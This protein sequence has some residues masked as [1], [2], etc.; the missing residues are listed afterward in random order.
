MAQFV[1][2][3]APID[4]SDQSVSAQ[5]RTAGPTDGTKTGVAGVIAGINLSSIFGKD[6]FKNKVPVT[7]CLK[8]APS[9]SGLLPAEW[10][11]K[12]SARFI[13]CMRTLLEKTTSEVMGAVHSYMTPALYVMILLATVIIGIK[14]VGG[15]F[16]NVKVEAVMFVGKVMGAL[17]VFEN[18]DNIAILFYDITDTLMV[19][20]AGGA[21][22]TFSAGSVFICDANINTSAY[23]DL[24]WIGVFDWMD[25]LFG[26]LYGFGP[27]TILSAGLFGIVGAGFFTSTIGIHFAMMAIGF[28]IALAMFLVRTATMVVMAYGSISL[29]MLMLPVFILT[30]FFKA[31]ESY[32]FQRWLSMVIRN[33]MQPAVM[34]AFLYFALGVL[35]VLLYKGSEGHY[36]K[37]G[38]IFTAAAN[39]PRKSK[40]LLD[41]EL[42]SDIRRYT[43]GTQPAGY[44]KV[45]EPVHEILGTT[46]NMLSA[47][48]SKLVK[49]DEKLFE[50]EITADSTVFT[51]IEQRCGKA[52]YWDYATTLY[53]GWKYRNMLDEVEASGILDKIVADKDKYTEAINKAIQDKSIEERGNKAAESLCAVLRASSSLV[54]ADNFIGDEVRGLLNKKINAQVP[55]VSKLDL[56]NVGAVSITG[57]STWIHSQQLIKL[58]VAMITL[59]VVGG[60]FYSYTES[61]Q[62]ISQAVTGRMGFA[63]SI[64]SPTIGGQTIQQRIRGSLNALED[65]WTQSLQDKNSSFADRI[66]AKGIKDG[67]K[68]LIAKR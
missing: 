53:Y 58:I 15:M 1:G 18:L 28:F 49:N 36:I 7:K 11:K 48:L 12:Y 57:D 34:I 67:A 25:C 44:T 2:P 62:R 9:G 66:G 37:Y 5:G 51:Q 21:Q 38:D 52:G 64:N 3:V 61:I 65:G 6:F 43:P 46:I 45:V 33:I 68:A 63:L 47:D 14:A 60:V 26:R 56:S 30:I 32:F 23:P 39:T 40:L 19:I 54:G 17:V 29:L 22:T 13:Y 16:R 10:Q 27:S 8:E 50:F 24:G 35:D 4:K 20:I 55:E 42:Y 31:T 41:G 59:T